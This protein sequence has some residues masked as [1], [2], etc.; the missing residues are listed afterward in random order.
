MTK[1]DSVSIVRL[2]KGATKCTIHYSCAAHDFPLR[3]ASDADSGPRSFYVAPEGTL[4]TKRLP[5]GRQMRRP[6]APPA[7]MFHDQGP[8]A[9]NRRHI[10]SAI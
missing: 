1:K 4:F 9:E 3:D 6:E 10:G 8:S 5:N 2:R 7:R